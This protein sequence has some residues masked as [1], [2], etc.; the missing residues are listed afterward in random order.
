MKV[1][2]IDQIDEK[3]RQFMRRNNQKLGSHNTYYIYSEN[4]DGDITGEAYAVNEL[5]NAGLKWCVYTNYI[6]SSDER[7]GSPGTINSYKTTSGGGIV[8][9]GTLRLGTEW[10]SGSGTGTPADPAFAGMYSSTF[11]NVPL[12]LRSWDWF[13]NRNSNNYDG[14]SES[15]DLYCTSTHV[16]GVVRKFYAVTE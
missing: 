5:T 4:M 9:A 16:Y 11:I 6:N 13:A 2:T 10:P 8:D 15:V 1:P 12:E 7:Y 14:Y 3:I